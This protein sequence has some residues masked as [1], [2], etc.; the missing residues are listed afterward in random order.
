MSR[1]AAA[2]QTPRPS[3]RGPL[4]PDWFRCRTGAVATGQRAPPSGPH[5]SGISVC[6]YNQSCSGVHADG[7]QVRGGKGRGSLAVLPLQ[8][9]STSFAA[10]TCHYDGSGR[11]Y[12]G[13]GPHPS[14]VCVCAWN[15][16][17]SGMHT[18]GRQV[19]GRKGSEGL[20]VL[21]RHWR[22][23]VPNKSVSL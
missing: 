11:H 2:V 17:C 1:Q 20:V 7:R 19:R 9:E 5:P 4:C 14:G 8:Q 22:S 13:S 23:L 18:D 21:P 16:S 15:Q 10:S 6:A 12:D 3:S